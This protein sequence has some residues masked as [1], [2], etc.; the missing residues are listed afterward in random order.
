MPV[1]WLMAAGMLAIKT[2]AEYL[3]LL[4]VAKFFDNRWV[5]KYFAVL[6]PVHILYIISAGFLG[7]FGNYT[8]KGRS[9]K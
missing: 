7:F 5:L 8:W 6:Q 4:P 9:V 2:V 3:F 1:L